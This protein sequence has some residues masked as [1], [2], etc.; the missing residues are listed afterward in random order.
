MLKNRKKYMIYEFYYTKN[1]ADYEKGTPY[2][3]SMPIYI[4]API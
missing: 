3:H 2:V 4:F 1:K